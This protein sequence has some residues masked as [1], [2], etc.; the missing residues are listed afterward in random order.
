[1]NELQEIVNR[2]DKADAILIGASNGLSITEGLHLFANNQALEEVFGDL[3]RKYGLQNILQGMMGRWPSEEEKWG[4]WSRLIERYCTEY[5]ETQ[6]MSDLKAI[7]GEKDYFVV[8][9]NGECHF[10][11][12]GFDEEKVFEVEGDWLHMQ[13][14]KPCHDTIYPSFEVAK[15]LYKNLKDGKV[16]T[17]MLPRC[18]K[19]GGMMEPNFQVHS[20]FIPQEKISKE[21]SR[22]FN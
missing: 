21:L 7:I 2:I 11:L 5:K 12:C 6:V 8:T 19:C 10:E 13:C 16:P 20:G 18:P 14:A 17:H 3:K 22:I 1:M 15:E 4:Y 9:S